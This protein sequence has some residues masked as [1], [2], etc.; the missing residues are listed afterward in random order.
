M[1]MTYNGGE[2]PKGAR[3]F[4]K[5]AAIAL[6]ALGFAVL[7]WQLAGDKAGVKRAEAPKVTTVIPLPPPPRRRRRRNARPKPRE[8][9]K[10][11]VPQPSPAPKPSEAPKPADNLP[12]QMTMNAPAQAGTDG[13]GIAAGDGG[14]MA[15]GGG[16][17]GSFGNATYA[18]YLGYQV[19]QLLS[20]D[21]RVQDS[22]GSRFNGAVRLTLDAS[23]RIVRATIERSSGTAQLDDAIA[24][25]LRGLGKFDEAPPPGGTPGNREF[26]IELN[27]RRT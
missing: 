13:F 8:E 9:P 12:K 24:D 20:R 4:V 22:G 1:D 15:G 26:R 11:S 18:K 23:G 6:A 17:T 5:P 7:V 16:G 27:G 3:R 21:K 25:A 19:E 10:T 14:G 2:P